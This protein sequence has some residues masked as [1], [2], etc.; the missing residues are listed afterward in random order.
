MPFTPINCCVSMH[1]AKSRAQ[2]DTTRPETVHHRAVVHPRPS[3]S[4]GGVQ[5]VDEALPENAILLH[6]GPHKT[7]TTAIQGS[8]AHA[9]TEL[10]ALGVTYPGTH[11]AHHAEARAVRR[12]PGGWAEDKAALP[13]MAKWD[14]LVRAAHAAPG[15]VVVSSEFFAQSGPED[16]RKII[17][18]LGGDRVHVLLAARNPGAIALSTWQQVLRDGKADTLEGWLENRFRR[19][20]TEIASEGFWT[21][22]DAS[23]LV[24]SWAEVV[25]PTQI[26][27]LVL[28]DRDRELLPASME[29]LLGVPHGVLPRRIQTAHNRSLTASEAELLLR[30]RATAREKLSWKQFSLL[31]RDG[32]TRRLLD[33][34]T[35]PPD[36]PRLTL[37]EWAAQQ[38]V[39]EAEAAIARLR[40]EDVQII[41]DL[42]ALRRLPPHGEP[43]TI[44]HLPVDLASEAVTGVMLAA[45]RGINRAEARPRRDHQQSSGPSPQRAE[46]LSTRDVAGLLASRLRGAAKRRLSR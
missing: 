27:V 36:E 42:E 33:H 20:T 37:P 16:R 25:D 1:A 12:H 35:P 22:A 2:R 41:G 46:D 38:S 3:A 29:R 34:R 28:D 44:E 7:G 10:S 31:F 23:A 14:D 9:R 6:I 5:P 43:A 11:G 18:E 24:R 39:A 8:L 32:F 4:L 13:P 19:D 30:V 17:S 40:N 21:W 15:R 26:H 45:A